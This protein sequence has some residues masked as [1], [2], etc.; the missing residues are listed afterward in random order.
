MPQPTRIGAPGTARARRRAPDE[1]VAA[2]L[3]RSAGRAQAR[4]GLAAAAA[5][6]T[7]AAELTPDPAQ[8]VR[9]RARC[10]PRQRAGG[11][12]RRRAQPARHRARPTRSTTLQR[13]RDR[14]DARS[15][16][17]RLEPGQRCDAALARSRPPPR[18]TGRAARARD[19]PG[20]ILGGAVRR[21]AQRARRRARGR[22][23][24]ARAAPRRQRRSHGRRPAAGRP[25][26]RISDDYDTA[27]RPC[28]SR[29]CGSSRSE[30][31]SPEERL[32]W[33]WQGSVVALELWDDESA[34]V[35]SHESVQIARQTGA[36][37]ELALALS[38]TRS[39]ARVLRRAV[40][41]PPRRRRDTIGHRRRRASPQ[42]RTARLI[43]AALARSGREAQR[44]I[45]TTL[46]EAGARGEGIGARH[47]RVRTRRPLQRR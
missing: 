7:R 24:R 38:C 32:R 45:E 40:R 41:L 21:T 12:L 11:R 4:G 31:V 39:R 23:T 34:Y 35:L 43:L 13:A 1:E 2:E 8:R 22:Q 20:R 16:G 37:S 6:L 19:L 17:I 47:L 44:L 25:G 9:A 42:R 18:A 28:R 3:E 36:L 10:G 15:A 26:R 30:K 29:P 33:L 46:R 5:F 27:M 14:P